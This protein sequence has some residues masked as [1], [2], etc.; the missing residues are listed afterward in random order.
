MLWAVNNPQLNQP[1]GFIPGPLLDLV[2]A[3]V[4][5]TT[6]QLKI[7]YIISPPIGAGDDVVY[8]DLGLGIGG[9]ATD[10]T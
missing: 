4:T 8:G 10:S 3:L 9:I 7:L 5:A 1:L 6:Q 2:L